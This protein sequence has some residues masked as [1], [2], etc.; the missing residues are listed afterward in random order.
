MVHMGAASDSQGRGGGVGVVG[1][2]ETH[3]DGAIELADVLLGRPEVGRVEA[4][5]LRKHSEP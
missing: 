4:Q 1:R 5:I 3:V 2:G